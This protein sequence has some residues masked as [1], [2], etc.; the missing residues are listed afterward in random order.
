MHVADERQVAFVIGLL[1]R[2]VNMLLHCDGWAERERRVFS[3]LHFHPHD[4]IEA[5]AHWTCNRRRS[6]LRG[7][8]WIEGLVIADVE[9]A[10]LILQRRA[11]HVAAGTDDGLFP[12]VAGLR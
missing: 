4:G 7:V 10:H 3:V 1:R 12:S 8:P 2:N 9:I 11:R 6:V 5:S